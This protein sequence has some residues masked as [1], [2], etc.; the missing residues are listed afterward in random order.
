MS[1]A[2]LAGVIMV[3]AGVQP[4]ARAATVLGDWGHFLSYYPKTYLL[5]ADGRAF[6]ITVHLM[7][8]PLTDWNR[9]RI[10]LRLT[11]PGGAV[12]FWEDFEVTNGDVT[13]TVPAGA[14]GVYLFEL[15]AKTESKGKEKTAFDGA[16]FWI[17]SS[18]ERAVVWTGD[19]KGHMVED[20][21]L[22]VQASVPRRWW[23]WVPAEV[24]TFTVRAQR[25]DRYMSQRED[26]GISVYSPRGQRM[27]VLW[28]QPPKT[29][30]QEY[31]QEM[32]RVIEVEPSAG[33]RFWALE[34]RLGDSHNYSKPN[35]SLD[36]VP[37]YLAR[38]PEEWFNPETGETPKLALYDDTPFIQGAYEPKN[39]ARWPNL[40]HWSP[41]PS[42]GDPDGIT[43]RGDS[44]FALWNPEGRELRFAL[45]DYVPRTGLGKDAKP[46]QADVVISGL[47]GKEIERL[48]VAVPHYHHGAP[49]PQP[50]PKRLAGVS[51]FRISGVERWWTFTYPATPLVWRGEPA[52]AGWSRFTFEVGTARNWYFY[53]PR[54]T[55]TFSVRARAQ[56][57]TDVMYLEVN[58]PDRTLALIYD[59][60]GE[61]EVAVPPGFDGKM[62]HLRADVGSATRMITDGGPD[63]RYLGIYLTLELKG[64]PPLLAPTW[65]QWFD[66]SAPVAPLARDSVIRQSQDAAK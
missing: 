26:W 51:L 29:P 56:H 65:E 47:D 27:Q 45:C 11:A 28:G 53:V 54:G 46:P 55:K 38:S 21:R 32:E 4:T 60:Q 30:P 13:C 48:K 63:T 10:P 33:G 9:T 36:G 41:C 17:E 24:S 12:V 1:T 6:S 3:G 50:L 58:T 52:D 18:L 61:K 37:P 44:S 5:N 31:R 42:L 14:K 34:I 62:W 40:Q 49:P 25:G 20:R 16:N 22:I 23:F 43:M 8:W 15:G 59:R 66:P 2:I 39:E 35:V 7:R 57:D 64:V 19:P